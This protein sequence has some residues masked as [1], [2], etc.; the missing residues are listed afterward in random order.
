MWVCVQEARGG[1]WTHPSLGQHRLHVGVVLVGAHSVPREARG[2]CVR[3]GVALGLHILPGGARE[4]APG[5]V[6]PDKKV[7]QEQGTKGGTGGGVHRRVRT[8]SG[9]VQQHNLS[10]NNSQWGCLGK[11]RWTKRYAIGAR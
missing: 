5:L 4:V 11:G 1:G 6:M 3:G 10:H 9:R 2:A 8:E 7:E